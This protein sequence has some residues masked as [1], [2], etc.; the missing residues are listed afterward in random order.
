[1]ALLRAQL[2]VLLVGIGLVVAVHWRLHRDLLTALEHYRTERHEATRAT[3]HKIEGTLRDLFQGLQLIARLPGVRSIDRYAENFAPDA[4]QTVQEIYQNLSRNLA[5]SEIYIV[6]AD[7]DPDAIDPRTGELQVPITTFDELILGQNADREDSANS[8]RPAVH[9]GAAH[10]HDTPSGQPALEEIE[11]HEYR[12]MRHQNETFHARYPRVSDLRG[13]DYP[14][15]ASPELVTCDNRFYSVADPDDADRAGLVYSVPFYGP[16]DAYKGLVAG[17]VLTRALTALLPDD[18]TAL[19]HAGYGLAAGRAGGGFWARHRTA[20]I[21]GRPAALPYSEVLAL[22]VRDLRAGWVLWAG[23]PAG[24]FQRR[25]DVAAARRLALNADLFIAALSLLGCFAIRQLDRQRRLVEERNVELESRVRERTAALEQ[26]RDAAL[27]ASRAKSEFLANMSHEIRTPMNGVMGMAELLL[28]TALDDTQRRFAQ[29]IQRSGQVLLSVINDILDF[30]K[31]ESGKLVLNPYDFELREIV[32]DTLA[33]LAGAAAAKG[34]ELTLD[35][36]EAC[37]P[38]FHADGVRLRQVLTNLVGNAIKFTATGEVRVHV[39]RAADSAAGQ[40]LDFVVED[41]GIGIPA[42]ALGHI[43]EPFRQADGS[44]TRRYGGTG[45]GLSICNNILGQM[46]SRLEVSS[47]PDQGSRFSFRLAL[48]RA[49]Q[50]V[51]ADAPEE[52]G[53]W[54]VLVVDDNATNREILQQQLTHWGARCETFGSGADA[55]ARLTAERLAAAPVDLLIVD[56]QMP[57]MDGVALLTELRDR[58]ATPL[59]AVLLSSVGEA[60]TADRQAHLDVRVALTKPVRRRELHRALLGVLHARH[61]A[62]AEPPAT[63]VAASCEGL[64]VL[65]A[66]DNPVN[67]ELARL[68]LEKAGCVVELAEDG[69][70]AIA[71]ATRPEPARGIDLV[72]M[73]CQMPGCDGFEATRQIRTWECECAQPRL[74]IVA[75]TANAL[76]G[77]RAR[78][79]AAGMDDYLSKPFSEEA[80]R[81][82]LARWAPPAKD[83]AMTI[84]V[85]AIRPDATGDAPLNPVTLADVRAL[86][87][88]ERPDFFRRLVE[89]YLQS[90]R[91]LVDEI[92]AA[93]ATGDP[94]RVHRAAHTLKSSS[95]NLG[96]DALAAL[97]VTLEQAARAGAQGELDAP[98]QALEV[99]YARVC[100]ALRAVLDTPLHA[101]ATA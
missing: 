51:V 8:A 44:T 1:A 98:A 99:E 55:L 61:D 66:E 88:P 20:I 79:L 92:A 64:R 34:L 53:P 12:W 67:R 14:T 84:A 78:C 49:A 2:I 62:A 38:A 94:A 29:T 5:V 75:L 43:F 97:C 31:I 86:Q 80:L 57:G 32:E 89:L 52:L 90:S 19:R 100:A 91:G 81:E 3:A 33:T 47:V 76:P 24:A 36:D 82:Q 23:E 54:R 27:A 93:C 13:G 48:A 73:D 26:A 39:R 11:I 21:E 35:Y 4:R 71:C 63:S 68:M 60:I 25:P 50:E 17:V 74:P 45:L 46:D 101:T 65:L 83:T 70:R 9:H 30:S 87:R 10:E 69:A 96:A 77:D 56:Y 37:A 15:L 6:P 22:N 7:L 41:T 42:D 40:V 95:A 58:I 72:L 18:T 59:P 16:D 28:G 85:P